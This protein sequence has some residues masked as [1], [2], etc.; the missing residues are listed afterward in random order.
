MKKQRTIQKPKPRYAK[1]LFSRDTPYGHKVQRDRTKTI[2]RKQ[3][4]KEDLSGK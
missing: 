2:P 1:E 4:Y 3:K